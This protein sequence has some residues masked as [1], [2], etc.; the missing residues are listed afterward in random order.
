MSCYQVFN[1][2]QV[3]RILP[4]SVIG[5][6]F[7]FMNYFQRIELEDQRKE[8]LQ[9]GL[10]FHRKYLIDSELTIS[11]TWIKGFCLVVSGI[12]LDFLMG[13]NKCLNINRMCSI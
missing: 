10:V 11:A 8:T 1:F 5:L 13:T 6:P 7:Q 3:S 2:S 9:T 12:W 4:L